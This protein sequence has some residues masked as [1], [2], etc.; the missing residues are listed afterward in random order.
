LHSVIYIISRNILQPYFFVFADWFSDDRLRTTQTYYYFAP[1]LFRSSPLYQ[2]PS[3]EPSCNRP[4]IP[5]ARDRHILLPSLQD[6]PPSQVHS[7]PSRIGCA[8][9]CIYIFESCSKITRDSRTPGDNCA[10]ESRRWWSRDRSWVCLCYGNPRSHFVPSA[11][12]RYDLIS[13]AGLASRPVSEQKVNPIHRFQLG[14]VVPRSCP[15]LY[16][17]G[18]ARLCRVQDIISLAQCSNPR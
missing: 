5:C 4:K 18:G 6:H 13:R 12:A 14:M 7:V 15:R 11:R 10:L 9:T 3:R 17:Y 2:S 8:H 16:R 1:S